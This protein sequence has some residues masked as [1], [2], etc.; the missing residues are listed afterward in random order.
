MRLTAEDG[1]STQ[2]SY[3]IATPADGVETY[4]CGPTGFVEAVV[5]KL[6]LSGLHPAHIRAERFS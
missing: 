4:V 1:Y 3:S 2:R 5:G 6:T